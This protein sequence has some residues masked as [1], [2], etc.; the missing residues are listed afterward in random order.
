MHKDQWSWT[1]EDG[2][3]IAVA[4]ERGPAS[5]PNAVASH[6][7]DTRSDKNRPGKA[8]CLP[9]LRVKPGPCKRCT[10]L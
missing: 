3:V 10:N 8:R 9:R 6:I 2:R 5:G 7:S 1:C 4:Q